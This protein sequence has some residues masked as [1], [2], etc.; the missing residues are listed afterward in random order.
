[1]KKNNHGIVIGTRIDTTL[2]MALDKLRVSESVSKSEFLKHICEF[3]IKHNKHRLDNDLKELF[4]KR[5]QQI[6]L[7]KLRKTTKEK[8]HCFYLLRN[9]IRTIF[10]LANSHRRNSGDININVINDVINDALE[11]FKLYPKEIRDLMGNDVEYL[12]KLSDKSF[13]NEMTERQ[14][15]LK[16]AVKMISGGKHDKQK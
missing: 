10:M 15:F 9:T 6:K 12:K 2:Y 13:L 1:M 11:E 4:G 16:Y 14:G 3:Y 5:E 8:R 7:K